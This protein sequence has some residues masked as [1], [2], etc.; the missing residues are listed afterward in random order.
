MGWQGRFPEA[1]SVQQEEFYEGMVNH[2]SVVCWS[3]YGRQA[4]TSELAEYLGR[5]KELQNV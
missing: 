1:L 3:V 2:I 5:Y 4:G